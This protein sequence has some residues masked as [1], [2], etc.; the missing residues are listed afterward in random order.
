MV[1]Q[2]DEVDQLFSFICRG[3]VF[4]FESLLVG[5]RFIADKP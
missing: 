3:V 2:S 4:G 5:G 1:D